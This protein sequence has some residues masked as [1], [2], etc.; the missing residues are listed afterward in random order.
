MKTAKERRS[1]APRRGS[2]LPIDQTKRIVFHEITKPQFWQPSNRPHDRYESGKCPAA[3]RVL[4]RL[5]GF[6]LS[7]CFGKRCGPTLAGR[8]QSVAVRLLVERSGDHRIPLDALLPCR[9][10]VLRRRDPI[11][12]FSSGTV[13]PLRYPREAE[14]FLRSCID[15]RSPSPKPRKNRT[16]LPAPPFTTSTLQQERPQTRMSVS[17][18]MSV[19]Q[20]LYEQGL[21]TY[22]RTD[23]VNLSKQA[24]G[25]CKEEII[26]LFGEKYSSAHNYKTK[27]KGAQEATRRSARRI[28]SGR[29]SKALRR[30]E[31][32]RPDLE[33]DGRLADGS[34]GA[35]PHHDRHRYLRFGR[36]VRRHGEVIRFD[37]F[38]KLYSESTTRAGEEGSASSPKWPRRERQSRANY[39]HG[40]L[41]RTAARYNELRS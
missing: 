3:R 7:P 31:V 2:R 19:A 33:A 14:T 36:P 41:H 37:G 5:V 26:K 8:V 13:H 35:R 12:P 22:M 28:S 1:P 21:I 30:K 39:G 29:R 34:C 40:T 10:T 16:A 23:S 25:Q 15:A 18:T 9:S 32:V 20:H 6:E 27:T 17:Q 38:L 24:I 4:D 11:K